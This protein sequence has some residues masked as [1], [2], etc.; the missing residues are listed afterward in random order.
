[1][2]LPGFDVKVT[3]E[4]SRF[5]QELAFS[6][7]FTR[8][9][10]S[11]K[12]SV[13]AYLRI[14]PKNKI[15]CSTYLPFTDEQLSVQDAIKRILPD[16][17]QVEVGD[18][19]KEVQKAAFDNGF[20]RPCGYKATVE[21][22]YI[23]FN[24][25]QKTIYCIDT[26]YR[27]L[28]QLSVDQVLT[29]L[30][31]KE[32]QMTRKE[33]IEASRQKWVDIFNNKEVDKGSGNCALCHVYTCG[34]CEKSG[35]KCPIYEKTMEINCTGTSYEVFSDIAGK[36]TIDSIQD[37]GKRL[38]AYQAAKKMIDLLDEILEEE[39]K[40][41]DWDY[42]KNNPGVYQP[43]TGSNKSRLIS[44]QPN[45]EDDNV[46]VCISNKTFELADSKWHHKQFVKV[47]EKY[48]LVKK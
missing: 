33:A 37:Y 8:P 36:K 9:L 18:R 16:N 6:C 4:E 40:T 46:V 5:L 34:T 11:K 48:E 10:G 14:V 45:Y 25:N 42:V 22:D 35:E 21:C 19:W 41:F 7:G 23:K 17:F 38:E 28:P 13:T 43:T 12:A 27:P 29:I 32:T 30:N 15:V 20:T 44:L 1:M 26:N 24:H 31:K 3:E 39:N 2:G 47:D